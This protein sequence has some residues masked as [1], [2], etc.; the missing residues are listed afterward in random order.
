MKEPKP[1]VVVLDAGA[2]YVDLIQKACE[3][4]GFP[5]VVLP[6]D[7]PFEELPDTTEAIV[8]SGGPSSSHIDGAPM[9]DVKVW[10]QDKIPTFNI[11]YG[12]QAFALHSGGHVRTRGYR[13][14]SRITTTLDTSQPIF[15]GVREQ[16]Q[17]L[18]T[19]GDFVDSV[20]ADVKIVG[21]H[22]SAS[23]DQVISAIARGPH[24]C[25]QFHP[26][27]T[28]DTP[29]GYEIFSNFFEYVAH[30]KPDPDFLKD[31]MARQIATKQQQIKDRVGDKHV[32]AFVS[33]GVDSVVA[34]MLARD[35]VQKDRLHMYYVDSGYMR[36]EDDNVIETL[37]NIGLDVQTIH[38]EKQFEQATATIDGKTVGPLVEVINPVHKRRIIGETF[39]DIQDDILKELG[40]KQDDIVL[41]QGTNAADRIETGHSKGG[42]KATDQIKEHHNQVQ[43]VRDLNPLEPLDDLFK[44][45]IRQLAVALG[46]PDHIAFRQPFPGPA[47]AIRILGLSGDGVDDRSNSDQAKIDAAIEK[48]NHEYDSSLIARLLPVRSVGVGGDARSHVQAVAIEGD[49]EPEK[50][51]DIASRL[52]NEFRGVINRVIYKLGGPSLDTIEPIETHPTREMR[53]TIRAADAIVMDESRSQQVIRKIEQFPVIL[54]PLGSDGKRSVVLRP[55][56]TRAHLT[57]QALVPGVDLSAS[58]F[59][60]VSNRI[61]TEVDGVSHVFTDL[62]NKPPGTTEW[63]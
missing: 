1:R 18:F 47:L 22:T 50:L 17:A 30:M 44:E 54:I 61:L 24:V 45:E 38:A 43:R 49:V 34:V 57:V 42:G 63:E 4:Q 13:E 6:I 62:T 33:G 21:E 60:T 52:T 9:P 51:P 26:E 29:Q 19:H 15:K 35:V 11:C 5:T 37:K 10:E 7:T 2:Q 28:D 41:L 40:F 39:V 58:F 36:I 27:V 31:R 53:E 55:L 12:M 3:R 48:I 59:E 20:G 25:V 14:D 32:I 23:G 16:T 46:L 8:V 56:F